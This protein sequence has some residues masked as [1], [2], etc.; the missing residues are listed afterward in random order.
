MQETDQIRHLERLLQVVVSA[1]LG[2]L[3]RRFNGAVCGHQQDRKAWLSFVKLLHK[4]QTA[5][6]GQAQV[7]QHHIAFVLG[8]AAQPLVT[9]MTDG[10]FEAFI[11]EHVAQIRRQT[12][13]VF[14]MSVYIA[15]HKVTRAN[16]R[17]PSRAPGQNQQLAQP[18]PV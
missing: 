4:F 2:R 17:R 1:Q 8:G 11:V 7:S 13:V 6:P 3:D 5:E 12:D 16:P 10:D 15:V 14:G 9:A 18:P